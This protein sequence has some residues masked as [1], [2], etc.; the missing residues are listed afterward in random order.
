LTDG[1]VAEHLA[2]FDSILVGPP[3]HPQA[4]AS[5]SIPLQALSGERLIVANSS[6]AKRA[7]ERLAEGNAVFE[8]AWNTSLTDGQVAAVSAQLGIALAL[9]FGAAPHISRGEVAVLPVEGF[10]IRLSWVLVHRRQQREAAKL[11]RN[12]LLTQREVIEA[13]TLVPV[14]SE[15]A[16]RDQ[17][18]PVLRLRPPYGL[19]Q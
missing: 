9:Y 16:Q 15:P 5:S 13:H 4:Q 1:L 14:A 17:S 19:S 18:G 2:D 3:S 8:M 10:P 12:Y 11:L 6:L 7:F